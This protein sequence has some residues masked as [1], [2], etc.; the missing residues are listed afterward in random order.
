MFE[1]LDTNHDGQPDRDELVSLFERL[2]YDTVTSEY[3]DEV[4]EEFGTAAGEDAAGS[5][6]RPSE[7]EGFWAVLHG[8]DA[9]QEPE[10]SGEAQSDQHAVEMY[11][12]KG[13]DSVEITLG[14]VPALVAAG[15]IT[16]STQVFIEGGWMPSV[17][18]ALL[19]A[20]RPAYVCLRPPFGWPRRNTW[21]ASPSRL[22]SFL[23]L[24]TIRFAA[25]ADMEGWMSFG[26][27]LVQTRLE[28]AQVHL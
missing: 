18:P 7:F 21:C 13:E 1:L 15:E 11:Y 12:V 9:G 28:L 22:S 17:V 20:K 4:L 27:E 26:E 6:I 24:L 16:D 2:G 14:E 25:V 3:I 8:K 19:F 5:V 10:P 23:A